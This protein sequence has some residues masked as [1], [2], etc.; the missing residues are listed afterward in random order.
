MRSSI[1]S[2]TFEFNN[3][4]ADFLRSQVLDR[5]R[6]QWLHPLGA[7]DI[8]RLPCKTAIEQNLAFLI[9]PDEMAEALY[10]RNP[11]PAMSV[12]RNYISGRNSGMQNSDALVFEQELMVVGRG[13]QRVER[14][15]PRPRLRVRRSGILVHAIL[16]SRSAKFAAQITTHKKSPSFY[17]NCAIVV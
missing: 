13:Y 1:S 9:P 16:A 17:E 12:Q 11:T 6:R 4:D 7:G 15:R 5:V 14:V 10:V 2:R 8:R 3:K